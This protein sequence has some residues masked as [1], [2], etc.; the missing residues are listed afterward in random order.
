[1]VRQ[2][3]SKYLMGTR[4]RVKEHFP[5]EIEETMKRLYGEARIGR[6]NANNKLILCF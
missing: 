2:A 5:P 4:F 3:A 1:M 6:Q